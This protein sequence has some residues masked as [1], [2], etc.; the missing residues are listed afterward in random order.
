MIEVTCPHCGISFLILANKKIEMCTTCQRD[1]AV[2]QVE[3]T[4]PIL[5]TSP[6]LSAR[7][8]GIGETKRN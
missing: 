7:I 1:F 5:V 4:R 3:L 8:T 2:V 6:K